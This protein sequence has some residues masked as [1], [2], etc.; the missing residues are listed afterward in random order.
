MFDPAARQLLRASRPVA[1]S[2]KAYGL[3]ELLLERAPAALSKEEIQSALWPKTIVSD[4]S[5]TNIVAEVRTAV[6]DRA[7]HPALIRTVHGFGYAFCGATSDEELRAPAG[8]SAPF[9][10]VFGNKKIPLSEGENVLGR[11]P[12][13]NIHVDHASVSRRH[14]RISIRGDA[15]LL[16]DLASRN[17]TFVDELRIASTSKL[18]DGNVIRLGPVRLTFQTLTAAGSTASDL[19]R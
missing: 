14:A 13:A 8:V 5:L 10:L 7:R 17:G 11:D 2:P 4:S 12:E 15:A 3:L 1:L 6:R 19:Q 16:E 9:Q 18:Q